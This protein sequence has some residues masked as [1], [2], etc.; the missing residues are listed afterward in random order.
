MTTL[1]PAAV[2][3]GR[4]PAG[5]DHGPRCIHVDLPELEMSEGQV[6]QLAAALADRLQLAVC[7]DVDQRLV[8]RMPPGRVVMAWPGDGGPDLVELGVSRTPAGE[9][10]FEFVLNKGTLVQRFRF[11]GQPEQGRPPGLSR[12]TSIT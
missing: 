3:V 4:K 5:R 9:L 1:P 11:R 12:Y 7:Q 2:P 6:G 8:E 10:W